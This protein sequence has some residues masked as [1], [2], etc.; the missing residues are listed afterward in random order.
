MKYI[1]IFILFLSVSVNAQYIDKNFS[2]GLNFVYTTNARIFLNPNSSDPV[3]RNSAFGLS[4]IINPGINFSYQFVEGV[5]LDL[6]LE[7]IQNTA[8]GNNEKVITNTGLRYINVERWIQINPD[9][10]ISI[11]S[12]TVFN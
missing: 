7:Y 2:L 8:N 4:D 3:E 6:N 11:L 9:R 12:Y 1:I 5:L 10:I